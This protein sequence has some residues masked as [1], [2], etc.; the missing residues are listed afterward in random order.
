MYSYKIKVGY[1][2]A[3]SSMKMT[4][5]SI[6][7]CFQDAAIFEGDHCAIP[8]ARLKEMGLAWILGSW[9]LE[10]IRRPNINENLVVTT[11]PYEFKGFIGYRNFTLETY[12]GQMLVKCASIWTLINMKTM[13]PQRADKDFISAYELSE[14]L[15]MNYLPRKIA[16]PEG[17]FVPAESIRVR[18]YQIDGNHHMNNAQYLKLSLDFMPEK[19]IRGLRIEY[20]KSAILGDIIYPY[21]L[22]D[23][24]VTWVKLANDKDEIY[25]VLEYTV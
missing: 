13:H 17:D 15:D 24:D 7:D 20:K 12:D 23:G 3:D 16:M 21:V 19:E 10:I 1:S 5:A 6:L 22:R 14:K 8:S 2:M 4:L 25:A 11:F 18:R 9:Q